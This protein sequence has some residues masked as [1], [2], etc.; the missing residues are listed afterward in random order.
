MRGRGTAVAPAGR[1]ESTIREAVDDGWDLPPDPAPAPQTEVFVDHARSII[2]RNTSPD[3]PFEQS[4]NPYRG[5]EHGCVY[6]Y[7]RPAQAYLNLSPGLD[8]ETK[9]F[10]KP[11]AAV[12][13]DAE[14]RK[15]GY[16]PSMIS[17][18]ANTDPYQP[19]ERKLGITRSILE[20][21]RRFHHPVGIVTKGAA[22]IERDLDLLTELARDELVHVAISIT[23]LDPEL[24][25]R[26]EPR[27]AAPATRLR[28]I[29]RLSAAGVPTMVFFSPVIPFINDAE[30]EAVLTAARNA[31]AAHASYILLRLP[32]EVKLLFRDW[33]ATHYPQKADHVMSL[34]QQMRGGRDNDS[35]F[36]SRMRGQGAYA[37][38]LEQRFKA[39]C[40]R[41]GLNL[42]R[43]PAL[44]LDRFAPPLAPGD[45]LGLGF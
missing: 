16:R 21:L 45:Q 39:A 4:I 34:V 44:R 30:M 43:G 2:T 17:L 24:K 31:G 6:C 18:G 1:F 15:P 13:L 9:L 11:N 25:R 40:R 10:Y 20:V 33:L 14:L 22:M 8:F 19:I 37:D 7:A 23:T 29:E 28:V 32:H 27:T 42:S 5:C 36:G 35:Q 12:L 41:L 26:L 38:V 3:L